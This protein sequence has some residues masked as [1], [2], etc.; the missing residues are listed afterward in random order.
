MFGKIQA[1]KGGVAGTEIFLGYGAAPVDVVTYHAA[2][3]ALVASTLLLGWD[4]VL[5]LVGWI[6]GH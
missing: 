6:G 4:E 1:R 3:S 5:R 2:H